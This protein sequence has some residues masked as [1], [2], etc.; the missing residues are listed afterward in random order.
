MIIDA[1]ACALDKTNHVQRLHFC[2]AKQLTSPEES[3]VETENRPRFL[4]SSKLQF[5][6]CWK[7]N[8]IGYEKTSHVAQKAISECV[9]VIVHY[10][11]LT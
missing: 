4:S 9:R 11:M 10:G 3:C 1:S 2:T 8:V 5:F 7:L 6:K